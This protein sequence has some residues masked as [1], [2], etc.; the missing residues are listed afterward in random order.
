MLHYHE[1]WLKGG[2]KKFF[3]SRLVAAV[4]R[5]LADLTIQPL[6]QVADRLLVAVPEE[7]VLP[8]MVE[9]LQ[10]VFGLAYI[11]IAW[12]VEG[13]MPEI[14]RCACRVME[15]KAPRSFA[16]RAKIA[17]PAEVCQT[18]AQHS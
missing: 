1:I 17:D 7:S 15:Q 2:N 16:V 13:G 8:L 12:E 5:S 9:R 11:G 14:A 3:L 10:K 4:K 18:G 6:E